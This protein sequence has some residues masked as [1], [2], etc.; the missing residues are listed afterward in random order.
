LALKEAMVGEEERRGERTS[1][2]QEKKRG[3][4]G[5]IQLRL[6]RTKYV[7]NGE[8]GNVKKVRRKEESRFQGRRGIRLK[9]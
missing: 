1:E 7:I 9:G 5:I 2:T 4:R 6:N 3:T 8:G